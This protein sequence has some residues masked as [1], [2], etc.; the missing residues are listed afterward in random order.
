MTTAPPITAAAMARAAQLPADYETG[1]SK[2]VELWEKHRGP[3]NDAQ[4]AMF[5]EAFKFGFEW[6]FACIVMAGQRAS[7]ASRAKAPACPRCGSA[8]AFAGGSDEPGEWAKF[9]GG[10]TCSSEDAS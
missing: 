8:C 3:L 1:L 10:P 5:A 7:A 2:T 4:R 9:C 6:A